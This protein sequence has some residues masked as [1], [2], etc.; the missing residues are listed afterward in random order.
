MCL[1]CS[2]VRKRVRVTMSV[3]IFSDEADGFGSWEAMIAVVLCSLLFGTCSFVIQA[4][5]VQQCVVRSERGGMR[6]I[7]KKRERCK[8]EENSAK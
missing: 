1:V 4:R 7:M 6:G 8:S 3:L 5:L 2:S